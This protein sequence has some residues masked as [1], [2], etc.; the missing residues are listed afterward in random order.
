MLVFQRFLSASIE[1]VTSSLVPKEDFSVVKSLHPLMKMCLAQNDAEYK[2]S[3][4]E[5]KQMDGHLYSQ[6]KTCR[7]N[8][9]NEPSANKL[10]RIKNA[11]KSVACDILFKKLNDEQRNKVYGEIYRISKPVGNTD[12]LWGQHHALDSLPVLLLSLDLSGCLNRDP[13]LEKSWETYEV[14]G[15]KSSVYVKEGNELPHGGEIG[16]INGI[17]TSMEIAKNDARRLS[18]NLANGHKFSCVHNASQGAASDVGVSVVLGNGIITPATRLLLEQWYKFFSTHPKNEKFL[19]ICFSQG[20]LHAK[21]ALKLLPKEWQERLCIVCIA[22]AAFIEP[23]ERTQI[24]HVYKDE[25]PVPSGFAF[26]RDRR[27][28]IPHTYKVSHDRQTDA[29]DPHGIEYINAARPFV[30][31]FIRENKLY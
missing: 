29:H 26:N 3:K 31:K 21:N 8:L 12:P 6:F 2:A 23:N 20:A 5:L 4:N 19:Q 1:V 17:G 9:K 24:V 27:T 18:E 28:V 30:Q 14:F 10:N 16:Y 7:H 22:P 15:E 11:V 25:D 13:V